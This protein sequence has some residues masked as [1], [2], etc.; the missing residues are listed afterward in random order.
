MPEE[1]FGSRM[2]E[3]RGD[4]EAEFAASEVTVD[5]T[6][7]TP[8]ENHNPLEPSATVAEWRDGELIVHDATQWVLGARAAFAKHFSVD[9][10]QVRVISPYIGGGFGCKGFFWPHE[11]MAA[12]AAKV[13]GRA[14]KLV[15]SREQM[16]TSAGH[17]SSTRQRLR[18]GASRDGRL[19]A[20]LHDVEGETARVG[21]FFEPAGLAT[22]MIFAAPA[23]VGHAPRRQA[24]HPDADGDARAGRD[25][26]H[27][28][29]G[30]CDGRA[31]VR[32]RDRSAR[33][34]APQ[35]HA[36]RIRRVGPAVLV[37]A[38]AGVLRPRRGGVRLER[39][40]ARAALDARRQRADRLGRRRRR[41]IRRCGRA[42]RRA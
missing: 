5:A 38:S 28:R 17:R 40:H 11:M 18:L 23:L 9:E 19:R 24:R 37:A 20:V 2:Q 13:T 30:Q 3:R 34:A 26:R 4:P 15:L 41:R 29:A 36:K 25:A 33:R 1:F 14:V 42:A 27:V 32:V 22:P 8:V 16:F 31:G 35:R 39:A 6:Y 7:R 21:A 10:T 12:M